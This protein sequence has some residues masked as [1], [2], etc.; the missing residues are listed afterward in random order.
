MI[1]ERMGQHASG[2]APDMLD[3]AMKLLHLYPNLDRD[4]LEH[5]I[6]TETAGDHGIDDIQG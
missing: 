1:A 3:Q 4:Y 6:R 5:R 2:S